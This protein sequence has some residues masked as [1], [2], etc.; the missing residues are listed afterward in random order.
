MPMIMLVIEDRSLLNPRTRLDQV[1][2][3]PGLRKFKHETSDQDQFKPDKPVRLFLVRNLGNPDS[4]DFFR[5]E[6]M[7]VTNFE[8]F[9]EKCCDL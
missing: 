6:L 7:P 2:C 1:R 9:D 5:I 8:D 4:D 3:R